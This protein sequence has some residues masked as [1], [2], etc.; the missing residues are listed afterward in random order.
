MAQ[1]RPIPHPTSIPESS[2]PP[3]ESDLESET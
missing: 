2:P 3:S 1:S